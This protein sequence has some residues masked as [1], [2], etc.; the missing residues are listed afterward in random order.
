MPATTPTQPVTIA[1]TWLDGCSG[2]HMS[3]L[4][5]DERLIEIAPLIRI[6][7]SPL[8]DSKTIPLGTDMGIIEGAVSNEDDLAK[9]HK[10]RKACKYLISLGDCAVTG[11]VPSM[12]NVFELSACYDRAYRE[13]ADLQQGTPTR[14]VPPLLPKVVPVHQVVDVDLFVPGC[15]PPADAI[16]YVLT[17]LLAGRHPHPLQLTRFGK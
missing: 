9:A 12:R 2:C 13:N 11:N 6:V 14:I 3:F 1:T 5:M 10:M 16:Y 17:E 4:D 7:Y 8:V 15:P